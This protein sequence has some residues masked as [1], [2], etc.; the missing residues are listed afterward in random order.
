MLLL[1]HN[2]YGI[3]TNE[4]FRY[5]EIKH[6]IE[7]CPNFS[8]VFKSALNADVSTKEDAESLFMDI[9]LDF[10][11]TRADVKV[12][13]GGIRP[14]NIVVCNG[15]IY[16]SGGRDIFSYFSNPFLDNKNCNQYLRSL[17]IIQL[18]DLLGFNAKLVN[19]IRKVNSL[20]ASLMRLL[21]SSK[22]DHDSK[23]VILFFWNKSKNKN[24]QQ[25]LNILKNDQEKFCH[26]NNWRADQLLRMSEYL[27]SLQI[28]GIK[29]AF[30]KRD[31][32]G[33]TEGFEKSKEIVRKKTDEF[34]EKFG[35][36]IAKFSFTDAESFNKELLKIRNFKTAEYLEAA[37]TLY[38]MYNR[39]THTE[40]MI[41]Y[42]RK[43][44]GKEKGPLY[45]LSYY[46]PCGNCEKM[47]AETTLVESNNANSYS[48]HEYLKKIKARAEI[49]RSYPLLEKSLELKTINGFWNK[50]RGRKNEEID[51]LL[52][53]RLQKFSSWSHQ[54]LKAVAVY[55]KS[56]RIFGIC[57]EK[58]EF[59]RN[60]LSESFKT[61]KDK[62][63]DLQNPRKHSGKNLTKTEKS[64]KYNTIVISGHKF[65][66]SRKDRP[67]SLINHN[68]LQ[69]QWDVDSYNG[70]KE[71]MW[72]PYMWRNPTEL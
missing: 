37:N 19:A 21:N 39:Y 66:D 16:L 44:N 63:K 28:L 43:Q 69:I 47:L 49:V 72:A 41:Q 51:A 48:E 52:K 5:G 18:S 29:T 10:G 70:K 7:D 17:R 55:I 20:Y 1:I 42:H 64:H 14:A 27:R 60:G 3:E 65:L 24:D 57:T 68:F 25:I 23:K 13:A 38:S 54:F 45:I 62:M 59:N 46:D 34:L 4:K 67:A 71:K 6:S 56:L 2:L 9:L 33:L 8:E 26:N 50:A 32:K 40:Y 22:V 31:M 11:G 35:K 61:V 15:N 58:L 12:L 30:L 53:E 36:Y